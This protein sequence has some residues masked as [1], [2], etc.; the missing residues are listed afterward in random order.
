MLGCT[1]ACRFV[2]WWLDQ[3]D[4]VFESTGGTVSQV[5]QLTQQQVKAKSVLCVV[6][7]WVPRIVLVNDWC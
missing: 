7:C 2:L 5:M 4:S 6:G 3:S 1:H